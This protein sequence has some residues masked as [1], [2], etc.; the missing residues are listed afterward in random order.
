MGSD[1][2]DGIPGPQGP[3]GEQGVPGKDGKDGN[4]RT[5]FMFTATDDK[6]PAPIAPTSNEVR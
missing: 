2:K 6:T 4:G 5:I 3:Q 1:G